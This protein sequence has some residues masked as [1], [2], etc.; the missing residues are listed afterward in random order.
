MI[1]NIHTSPTKDRILRAINE[2]RVKMR[3]KWQ[4]VL[5][6]ILTV[7]GTLLI[8]FALLYLATLV[9]FMLRSSGMIIAPQFG[10]R[11]WFEL[12]RSLPWLIV[13][14]GIVFAVTL[15]FLV[16]QYRFSY[17][18]PL[19]YSFAALV[20]VVGVSSVIID[21]T[22]FHRRTHDRF[23]FP[24]MSMDGP[25]PFLDADHFHRV[26][27]GMISST[28]ENGIILNERNGSS[29]IVI[30]GDETQFPAG[31]GFLTGQRVVVFGE[32]DGKVIRAL[33]ARVVGEDFP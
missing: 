4:F 8:F 17:R 29:S 27:P 13:S 18:L 31:R 15:F 19:L 20:V 32:F 5:Q 10:L 11:G 3:P 28:T 1:N 21:M 25:P 9:L 16:R 12:L 7:A 33:G 2:G 14:I 23:M 30:F 26:H 24:P 6:S 22:R